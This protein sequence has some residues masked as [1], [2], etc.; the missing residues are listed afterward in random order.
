[1]P[2]QRERRETTRR[3]LLD[4]TVRSLVEVGLAGTTT[5]RICRAAGV[6]Q[7]ALFRHFP[8]KAELLAAA[9]EDL[10]A[11]LIEAFR[12]GLPALAGAQDRAEAAVKV[13][14]EVFDDPRLHAAFELYNAS[15]TDREMARRLAPVAEQHGENLRRLARQL[16]PDAAQRPDFDATVALV[17]QAMQGASLGALPAGHREGFE[18]M[19]RLVAELVRKQVA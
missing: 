3:A 12:D 8:S 19:L 16:F 4:A 6:S 14:W 18:P 15:R 2:T 5:P 1:M 10:F 7:G 13:L 11:R 17:V 9:A